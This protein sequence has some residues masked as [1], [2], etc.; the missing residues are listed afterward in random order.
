MT[1]PNLLTL[2]RNRAAETSAGFWSN[3][4]IYDYMWLGEI[5]LAQ[6]TGCTESSG[7]FDTVSG[8][9]EYTISTSVGTDVM[10]ISRVTWY[11][12]PLEKTDLNG[13]DVLEGVSYG[14]SGQS[15]QPTAYYEYANEIGF[16]PNP[17]AAQECKVF[18]RAKPVKLTASST[19]F[20]VP[21]E[22]GNYLA[23][24][25]LYLMFMKDQELKTEAANYFSQWEINVKLAV[26]D[27]AK[28]KNKF[29]NNV[30]RDVAVGTSWRRMYS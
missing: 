8:T 28:R 25:C 18:Y 15:G 24:Y 20:T 7:T 21:D 23:E 19:S 13:V 29:R 26:A 14:S 3:L 6:R 4:E 1:P 11:T 17:N 12:Y 27:W 5:I 9:R 16:S 22:Y 2:I 30:V 10:T